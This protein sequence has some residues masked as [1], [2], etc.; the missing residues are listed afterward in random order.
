LFLQDYHPEI[1]LHNNLQFVKEG[2]ETNQNSSSIERLPSK[3]N[4]CG[5]FE[6]A[7]VY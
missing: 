7:I 4:V 5:G 2:S 6:T 3:L 1:K